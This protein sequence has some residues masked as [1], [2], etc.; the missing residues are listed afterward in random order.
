M[1]RIWG[2]LAVLRS[3]DPSVAF[4]SVRMTEWRGRA[5]S[6]WSNVESVVMETIG[7]GIIGFGRI[8]AE[9]AGWLELAAGIR[10]VAGGGLGEWVNVESRLGQG[11]SCGGPGAKEFRPGWRN[12]AA[13]GG[14]GLYDWGSHFVDQLWRLGWPARPV[15]VFGQLRG[16]VWSRDCD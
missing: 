6:A 3:R 13:F 1:G 14:G 11:S 15:R 9:H 10:A 2:R 4:S 16:N 7:V 5:Q 8:G 12:E